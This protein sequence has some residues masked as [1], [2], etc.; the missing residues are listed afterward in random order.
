MAEQQSHR[1]LA[2]PPSPATIADDAPVR[3]AQSQTPTT[4][5]ASQW[6]THNCTDLAAE[7]I[8]FSED[9]RANFRPY[10]VWLLNFLT[11]TASPPLTLQPCWTTQQ[12]T[13]GEEPVP[14]SLAR[15]TPART[16]AQSA[17]STTVHGAEV[18]NIHTEQSKSAPHT[19]EVSTSAASTTVHGAEV[20][21]MHT[22]QSKSAPHTQEVSTT[23]QKAEVINLRT[24]PSGSLPMSTAIPTSSIS[25]RPLQW[26]ANPAPAP[27]AVAPQRENTFEFQVTLVRQESEAPNA[28]RFGLRY[29]VLF[30]RLTVQKIGPGGAAARHNLTLNTSKLPPRFV[31]KRYTIQIEDAI[32][33]VNG[34]TD[35]DDMRAALQ[36]AATVQLLIERVKTRR[37]KTSRA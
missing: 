4:S 1:W 12:A 37:V 13:I 6:L 2:P 21:N 8:Q 35:L 23:M 19:Q 31:D 17:A 9:Q 24:K 30:D 27:I 25:G 3:P 11:E 7:R 34:H 33:C 14:S 15:T 32:M 26:I 28:G 16:S 29:G 20:E 5:D 10:A 18:V 36:R 22:E